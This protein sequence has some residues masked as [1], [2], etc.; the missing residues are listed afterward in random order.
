MNIS[1]IIK[2]QRKKLSLSQEELAEKLYVTRQTIGNWENDKSYPDIHSLILLSQIFDMTIDNLVKGDLEM[3][4]QIIDKNDVKNYKRSLTIGFVAA[5]I[6]IALG[7]PTGAIASLFFDLGITLFTITLFAASL[8]IACLF[9]FIGVALLL[10]GSRIQEKY[11]IHTF[12]EIIAFSKGETL[13]KIAK[14]QEKVKRP[15]Q[16]IFMVLFYFIIF[17]VASM[18]GSRLLVPYLLPWLEMW[19]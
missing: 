2:E 7:P 14:P 11:D 4:E 19:R 6:A 8:I 17:G 9:A 1:K 15:Y 13:D 12:K 16:Y 5:L 18:V 10:K 3:M